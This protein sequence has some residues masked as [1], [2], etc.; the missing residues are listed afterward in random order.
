MTPEEEIQ[1]LTTCAAHWKTSFEH[2]RAHVIRLR[3]A[4]FEYH[5]ALVMCD[6]ADCRL[7]R[8]YKLQDEQEQQQELLPRDE[9]AAEDDAA[10]EAVMH[11]PEPEPPER[12]SHREQDAAADRDAGQRGIESDRRAR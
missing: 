5:N 4:L 12:L 7:V 9:E 3:Q 8:Q 1:A 10:A 11:E 2:E 6:C